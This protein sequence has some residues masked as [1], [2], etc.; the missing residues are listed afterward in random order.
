MRKIT[1]NRALVEIIDKNAGFT[2]SISCFSGLS[3]PIAATKHPF[4]FMPGVTTGD[5]DVV[6]VTTMSAPSTASA[7][8]ELG[9]DRNPLVRF[10]VAKARASAVSMSNRRTSSIGKQLFSASN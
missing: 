9:V 3:A 7:A 10:S 5:L 8:L 4:R 6:H 1:A 2:G